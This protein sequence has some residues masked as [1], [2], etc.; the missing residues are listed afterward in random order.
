MMCCLFFARLNIGTM[1]LILR[2]I[3]C[4]CMSRDLECNDAQH[5]LGSIRWCLNVIHFR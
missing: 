4:R 2:L 3:L 5:S 1:I